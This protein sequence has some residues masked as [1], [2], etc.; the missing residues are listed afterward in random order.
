METLKALLEAGL[1]SE[2]EYKR[3]KAHFFRIAERRCR[4]GAAEVCVNAVPSPV[5]IL[6]CKA[7]L[8]IT[9]AAPQLA[10]H[11]DFIFATLIEELGF[12]G[13]TLLLA[14]YAFLLFRIV[15]KIEIGVE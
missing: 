9:D 15:L 3:H 11:T 1:I 2:A 12:F 7:S 8:I 5:C 13:G 10:A 6:C 4:K 14:G